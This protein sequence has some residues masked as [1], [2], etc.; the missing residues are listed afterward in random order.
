MGEAQCHQ[1]ILGLLI[2]DRVAASDDRASL[3]S[4]FRSPAKNLGQEVGGQ[5]GW[6]GGDVEGEEWSAP[7]GVHIGK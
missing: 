1:P 6:K 5:L 3:T 4:L 7:H 2:L